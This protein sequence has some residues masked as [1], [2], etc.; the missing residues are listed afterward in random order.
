MAARLNVF[1]RACARVRAA[2]RSGERGYTLIELLTAMT[3]LS[4]VLGALTVLFVSGAKAELDLNK[5]FQAQHNAA[6]ALKKLRGEIHCANEALTTGDALTLTLD[7]YCQGG[8]ATVIWC[9]AS[10]GSERFG[11]FR[12][13]AG[14]CDA[15][16]V[17]WADFLTQASIF[18]FEQPAGS[19]EKI[20][21]VLP[22][23]L[24]PD[25]GAAVYR[26]EDAIVLRNS[27][28]A[29]A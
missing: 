5:R 15:S 2:R 17:R 24:E 19:L 1:A 29:A 10:L 14:S 6:L 26:I 3:I 23:D 21:I 11:L 16:D 22:V 7:S 18:T 13:T 12:S 4:T 25:A 20:A 27:E 9:T 28:R 8:E